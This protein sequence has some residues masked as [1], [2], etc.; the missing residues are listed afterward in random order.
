[1]EYAYPCLRRKHSAL[2]S[3]NDPTVGWMFQMSAKR[4][5][6]AMQLLHVLGLCMATAECSPLTPLHA[7]GLHNAMTDIP[8]R[9]FSSEP[10]WHCKTDDGLRHLFNKKLPLPKQLHQTSLTVFH[11]SSALSMKVVSV[12]RMKVSSLA[13]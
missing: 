9:S 12:L 11:V 2:F 6:V 4:S 7:K 3:A 5:V 1:M 10:K 8:S 13:K